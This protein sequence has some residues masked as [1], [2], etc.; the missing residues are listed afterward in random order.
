VK[1]ICCNKYE[2]IHTKGHYIPMEQMKTS[3]CSFIMRHTKG[4]AKLSLFVSLDIKFQIAF[5]MLPS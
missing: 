3:L 5:S 4:G 2:T 1:F